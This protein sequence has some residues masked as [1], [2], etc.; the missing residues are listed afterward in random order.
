MFKNLEELIKNIYQTKGDINLHPP[1]FD[2]LEKKYVLDCVNSTFVSSV[3]KYVV[4]FEQKIS[5]YTGAKYTVAVVNGTAALQISLLLAGI[6]PGDEVITQAFTFVATANAISH[7]RAKP[8]FVDIDKETMGLSPE[9]LE[10]FLRKNKNDRIKACIPVHMYGHPARIDEIVEICDKYDIKVIEDATESLGSLYKSK[11]C[12]TFGQMGILSFNGNKTITTGG[13]GMILTDDEKLAKRAKHLTT[14]AKLPH[15]WAY[16]HD[17]VG[18][19]YRLPNINAALGVAQME[20]LSVILEAKRE[21]AQKYSDFF[22]N[23][24]YELFKEPENC[25]S[26]YWLNVL[27]LKNAQEKEGFLEYFNEKGI[28]VRNCWTLLN[29]YPMY[30]NCICDS[31]DNS[32]YIESV[33]VNIPSGVKL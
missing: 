14:T 18:Y 27:L 28:Q 5:E 31:L 2:N 1:Y 7:C 21:I 25:R 20:K 10:D 32:K 23:T 29:K 30:E 3:G 6:E 22:E 19:N 11:H 8:V 15:K 9:K 24:D 4:L 33:A 12:G 26:N 16:F 17:E 13:G